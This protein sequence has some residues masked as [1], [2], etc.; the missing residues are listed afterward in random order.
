M[1]ESGQHPEGNEDMGRGTGHAPV[2][3]PC[4]GDGAGP[5]GPGSDVPQMPERALRRSAPAPGPQGREQAPC[6]P[7]SLHPRD[8][9][10]FDLRGL[11]AA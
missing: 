10:A 4:P 7:S 2:S 9:H 3:L 1:G 6:P 11:R 8:R 5:Q